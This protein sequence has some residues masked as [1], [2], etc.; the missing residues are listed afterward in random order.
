MKHLSRI[1]KCSKWHYSTVQSVR[2]VAVWSEDGAFALFFRPHPGGYES[3]RVPTPGNLS[4]KAKKKTKQNKTNAYANAR[5]L[6][7]GGA[8]CSWNWLMH[9]CVMVLK[10]NTLLSCDRFRKQLNVGSF[11]S[12]LGIAPGNIAVNRASAAV[13]SPLTIDDRD[14]NSYEN[15]HRMSGILMEKTGTP[16]EDIVQNHLT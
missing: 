1:L 5:W 3:S 12:C 7:R 6:A 10:I 13:N 4:S 2:N 14:Y 11:V 8:G 16:N 15:E 9:K